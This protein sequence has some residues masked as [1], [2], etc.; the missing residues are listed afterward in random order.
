MAMCPHCKSR[1]G[2]RTQEINTID[3]P[4]STFSV[5]CCVGCDAI[6]HVIE[7]RSQFYYGKGIDEMIGQLKQINENTRKEE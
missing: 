6:I 2:F 5:L 4:R 3:S 7:P 1:S